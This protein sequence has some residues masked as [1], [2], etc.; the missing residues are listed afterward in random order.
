MASKQEDTYFTPPVVLLMH[1]KGENQLEMMSNILILILHQYYIT[2]LYYVVNIF[3]ASQ[4][5]RYCAPFCSKYVSR[6]Y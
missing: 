1:K 2:P 3:W 5:R 6:V 4:K